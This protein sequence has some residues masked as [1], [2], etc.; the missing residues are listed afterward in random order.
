MAHLHPRE[1]R[2]V[3]TKREI[4]E[5]TSALRVAGLR[6]TFRRASGE[7]VP[8]VDVDALEVTAGEFLVLLGPSG[9][10]KTTLLRCI[11]GLETPDEGE[12]TLGE[13]VVFS[14]KT[15]TSIPVEKRGLSMVFQSYALWPHM[16]A[17][18]NVMYPLKFAKRPRGSA[19]PSRASMI[20]SAEA[21][22]GLVDVASVGRQYPTQMS[23]GQQQRVALARALVDGRSMILLD[24]PLSNVDARVRELLRH[25]LSTMHQKIGF[26]AVYVTHDQVEAMDLAT[27]IVV[28]KSGQ[29][30]QIGTPSEI[31]QRPKSRYVAEFL[32]GVNYFP[33][34]Q[35]G[36]RLIISL[37]EEFV[38][39]EADQNLSR[40]FDVADKMELLVRPEDV[41]VVEDGSP[42]LAGALVGGS[43]IG[44][45]WDGIIS[46]AIG[47]KKV[48]S[49][50]DLSHLVGQPVSF[51]LRPK[52]I[53]LFVAGP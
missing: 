7:M 42:G 17:L 46:T 5:S 38:E 9:C 51:S 35:Q 27:R 45:F 47:P 16:T 26:T 15:N 23:G 41:V 48:R 34:E 8:A 12:I 50:V 53:Q 39:I 36:N 29:V 30:A 6:K 1:Q 11:A 52:A 14:S 3:A 4:M 40:D 24:E 25:E 19:R 49:M 20:S 2:V 32:G 10:G 28:M 33:A 31:Y 21:A 22:L 18:E 44:A 43:L 13:E 37:G